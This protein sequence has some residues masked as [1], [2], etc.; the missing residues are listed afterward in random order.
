MTTERTVTV[1][2]TGRSYAV[3]DAAVVATSVG[4]RAANV[5]SAVEGAASAAALA[6][7]V[8]AAHVE[9]D[10][11]S[12]EGFNVWPQHDHQGR[13]DGYECRHSL[14]FRCPSLEVA[15]ALVDALAGAV[16]NRLQVNDVSLVV[17]DQA[18]A[19]RLAREAAYADAV[20]KATHLAGLAGA[21]LGDV[22]SVA[23]GGQHH[24]PVR[25]AA[26][27]AAMDTSF[28]PGETAVTASLTVTFALA[29][30]G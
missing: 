29:E 1:I 17:S 16:G 3:P 21:T 9:A 8:A 28:A 19:L 22:L 10:R 4:H 24:A 25:F 6:L 2:G 18:D 26:Q 13:L 23:E 14:T 5:A 7:E 27:A 11:A 30:A 20:A 12:T 15:G